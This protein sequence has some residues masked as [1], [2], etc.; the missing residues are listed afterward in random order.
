MQP[1]AQG[2]LRCVLL[3][4]AS[5]LVTAKAATLTRLPD[6]FGG[7]PDDREKFEF[8][9]PPYSPKDCRAYLDAGAVDETITPDQ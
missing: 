6:R 8:G 5:T 7:Y 3:G 1:N 2:E 4:D 9:T